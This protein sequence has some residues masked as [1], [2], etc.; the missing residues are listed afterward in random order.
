[1]PLQFRL[2]KIGAV[3]SVLLALLAAAAL[4]STTAAHVS[5]ATLSPFTVRGTSFHPAE[6]VRVTVSAEG[7]H[8]KT[9]TANASG[10]FRVKFSA[11]TI[12]RC[13][14]YAVRAKG[15]RGS[16]AFIRVIPECAPEGSAP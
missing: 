11:V 14:A 13:N 12:G 7:S 1:M 3:V 6:R 16:T 15:N 8:T 4:A 5:V 9:V 10:R 2:M